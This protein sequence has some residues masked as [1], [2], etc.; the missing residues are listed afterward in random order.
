[1]HSC[2]ETKG[3]ENAKHWGDAMTPAARFS[4]EQ[5]TQFDY[6]LNA[7]EQASQADEP[8]AHGY[9]AKRQALFAYVR[10]LENR[11]GLTALRSEPPTLAVPPVA[12]ESDRCP[13]CGSEHRNFALMRGCKDAWHPPFAPPTTGADR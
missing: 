1:M 11:P 7:F 5:R 12:Q 6:L 3:A 9:A 4:P 2:Q 10:G 8:S 13:T